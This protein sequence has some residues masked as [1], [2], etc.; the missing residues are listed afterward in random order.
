[1]ILDGLI[2]NV[3][4]KYILIFNLEVLILF[5]GVDIGI[6]DFCDIYVDLL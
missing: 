6:L 1:M 4:I 5:L 2:E 3:E